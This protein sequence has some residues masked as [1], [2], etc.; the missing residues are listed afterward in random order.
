MDG[1]NDEA[2]VE[3]NTSFKPD[4]PKAVKGWPATPLNVGQ[5]V[6]VAVNSYLQPVIFHRADRVFRD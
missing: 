5:V 2:P 3:E 6:G 4:V 1:Q